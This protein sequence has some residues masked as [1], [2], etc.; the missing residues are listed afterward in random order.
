MV[1]KS[2]ENGQEHN[3]GADCPAAGHGP[4]PETVGE[5]DESC[6]EEKD[7]PDLVLSPKQAGV[8]YSAVA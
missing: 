5:S 3:L 8:I 7:V 1:Y 4:H 2:S 6:G